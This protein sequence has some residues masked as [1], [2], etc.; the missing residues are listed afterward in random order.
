MRTPLVP[1]NLSVLSKE[2]GVPTLE[3][4][5]IFSVGMAMHTRAVER[6]KGAVPDPLPCYT[7]ARKDN[8]WLEL[9]VP[10]LV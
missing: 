10:V 6:Y 7:M 5:G 9:C 1:S 2:R 4:S 3:P 8:Q